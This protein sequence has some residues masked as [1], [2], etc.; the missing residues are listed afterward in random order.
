TGIEL[1]SCLVIERHSDRDFDGEQAE[2]RREFDDRVHRY[3]GSI[4][5]W[6]A[7]SITDYRRG[8]Q[9]SAF[10]AKVHFHDFLGIVPSAAGIGHE[11]RLEQA[12]E[13]DAD[14]IANKEIGIEK[15]QRQRKAENHDEDVPHAFLRVLGADAHDL[16]AVFV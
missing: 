10:L 7:N 4:F 3:R 5:E 2:E 15:R 8:M 12:E 6:I 9:V 13:G 1:E 14:Q 11:N 16:L